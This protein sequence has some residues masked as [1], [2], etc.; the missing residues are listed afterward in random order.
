M[1]EAPARRPRKKESFLLDGGV[2]TRFGASRR[3]AHQG[4]EG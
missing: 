3:L 2:S 4:E 1:G